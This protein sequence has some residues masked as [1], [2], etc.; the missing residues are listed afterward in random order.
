MRSDQPDKRV[1]NDRITAAI[2]SG[3]AE[4]EPDRVVAVNTRSQGAAGGQ[5]RRSG[6]DG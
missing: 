5:N 1:E 6:N 4:D 2:D 3:R